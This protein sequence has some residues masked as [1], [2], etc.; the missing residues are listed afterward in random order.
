METASFNMLTAELTEF[1]RCVAGRRP[2]PTPLPQILRGL[3]VFEAVLHSAA[4]RTSVRR[5]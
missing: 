2:F 3:E 1:A 5:G 4:T